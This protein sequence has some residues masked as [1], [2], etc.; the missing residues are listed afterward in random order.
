MCLLLSLNL[1]FQG[2][3]TTRFARLQGVVQQR[4]R[5]QKAEKTPVSAGILENKDK[6]WKAGVGGNPKESVHKPV[7]P[8]GS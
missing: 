6:V 2:W 7:G 3:A 4:V 1:R 5:S 8:C